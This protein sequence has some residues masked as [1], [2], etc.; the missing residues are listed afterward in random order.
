MDYDVS[1]EGP[2]LLEKISTPVEGAVSQKGPLSLKRWKRAARS[3]APGENLIPSFEPQLGK[4]E[5]DG[6]E[7]VQKLNGRKVKKSKR[8][9]EQ[10][11]WTN[12]WRRLT[13][14][15]ASR[16][17]SFKLELQGAWEPPCNSRPLP[18]GEREKTHLFVSHGN[19]K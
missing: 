2:I 13:T 19:K 10:A 1:P 12:Q 17:Y 3:K 8:D 14:S 6:V 9:C 4:R 7:G 11:V 15:P 18:L 16:Q 5:E